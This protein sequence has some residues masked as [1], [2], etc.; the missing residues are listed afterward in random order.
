MQVE[1]NRAAK[2]A[3]DELQRFQVELEAADQ[4]DVQ[5]VQVTYQGLQA[6]P[7]PRRH[8]AAQHLGPQ[9]VRRVFESDP[10]VR[11]RYLDRHRVRRDASQAADELSRVRPEIRADLGEWDDLPGLGQGGVERAEGI[12]DPAPFLDRLAPRVAAVD[13]VPDEGADDADAHKIN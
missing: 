13:H 8:A 1:I 12:G 7:C 3:A 9:L 2:V 4:V 11:V 6:D 10:V 5:R